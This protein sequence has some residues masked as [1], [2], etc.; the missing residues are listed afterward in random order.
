VILDEVRM[1]QTHV[2]RIQNYNFIEILLITLYFNDYKV[3]KQKVLQK[4]ELICGSVQLDDV[5]V[6][7][8]P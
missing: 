4:I 1:Q 7:T 8:S 6:F 2:R 3:K 5:R